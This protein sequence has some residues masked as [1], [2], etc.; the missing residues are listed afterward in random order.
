MGKAIAIPPGTAFGRLTVIQEVR[1]PGVKRA[2]LCRCE[3]GQ[4]TTVPV[5]HLRSG[6][7]KSCGCLYREP[8]AADPASLN[9]GE[10]P[11]HG[12]LAAGRVALVDDADY[13]LVMQYRWHVREYVKPNGAK[14]GPY[15]RTHLRDRH[16][17]LHNLITGRLYIDH[18]DGDGLNCRRDNLRGATYS[19]NAANRGPQCGRFKGVDLYR[20]RGKWRARINADGR[21]HHLGY[22]DDEE[23]AA[24]AYDS[25]AKVLHGVFARLNFPDEVKQQAS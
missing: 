6:H 12:K 23:D 3:C 1:A 8:A 21:E 18:A 4:M 13:D 16:I 10:I 24:R 15:A 19:Q 5:G 20:A 17:Y 11:L 22:F 14:F 25:A 2:M 9:P 7:T